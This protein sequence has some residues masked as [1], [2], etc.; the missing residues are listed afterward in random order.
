MVIFA[1]YG[2]VLNIKKNLLCT[3]VLFFFFRSVLLFLLSI[4]FLVHHWILVWLLIWSNL[5]SLTYATSPQRSFPN[6]PFSTFSDSIQSIFGPNISLA[7]VLAIFFTLIE[8]PDLLNLHFRQQQSK[9]IGENK[10]QIS[11]W[12][13]ALVN[14]LANQLGAKRTNTLFS[15]HELA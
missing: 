12:I 5:I 13:I 2:C 3:I 9:C 10:V 7:T 4:K 1:F 14:A 15:G 6:I 11:G 8:N